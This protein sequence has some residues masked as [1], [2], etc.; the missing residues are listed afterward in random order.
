MWLNTK[1]G[2]Y[3]SRKNIFVLTRYLGMNLPGQSDDEATRA[4][5]FTSLLIYTMAASQDKQASVQNLEAITS[6]APHLGQNTRFSDCMLT[7]QQ[8]KCAQIAL[9]EKLVPSFEEFAAEIDAAGPEA[10]TAMCQDA[11]EKSRTRTRDYQ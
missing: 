2:D 11:V 1:A 8:K 9:D 6:L 7:G 10:V 4:R 3:E 5:N